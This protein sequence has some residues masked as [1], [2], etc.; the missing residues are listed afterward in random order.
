MDIEIRE[1]EKRDYPEVFLLWKEAFET[2]GLNEE[3]FC[4]RHERMKKNND[5]KTYVAIFENIVIGF[6][7]TVQVM[8][9]EFEIGYLKINGLAVK[10]IYRNKGA[11][12]K[13]L[14]YAENIA[15]EKGLSRIILNSGFQR[16]EAHIFYEHYGF[17]KKSYCFTRRLI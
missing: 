16:T 7:T 9:I 15:R 4:E 17:D 10:N 2:E 1:I 14:K 8:A 3:N 5:Y 6:I 11:G 13:L 12:T